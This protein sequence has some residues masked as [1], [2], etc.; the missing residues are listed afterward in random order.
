MVVGQGLVVLLEGRNK[1]N[2]YY[3]YEEIVDKEEASLV[4]VLVMICLCGWAC[5]CK[6]YR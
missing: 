3:K 6:R 1:V 2:V 4:L 5:L